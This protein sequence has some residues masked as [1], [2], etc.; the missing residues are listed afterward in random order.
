M[1]YPSQICLLAIILFVTFFFGCSKSD[2]VY[3]VSKDDAE[4]NEAIAKARETLPQFWQSFK[5]PQ[6]GEYGFS[7]KVK[8]TDKNEV[9]HFWVVDIQQKDGEL[10]GT[11]NNDPEK[12]RSVKIGDRIQIPTQDISDWTYLR[13]HKMVGNYTL[14]LLVKRMS[15]DEAEK[16]K[17]ILENP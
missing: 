14:R 2:K 11:I 6:I 8:I 5:H 13:N 17:L 4:M 9:E 15:P 7:L 10:Y 1:K 12:V 3:L 16:C